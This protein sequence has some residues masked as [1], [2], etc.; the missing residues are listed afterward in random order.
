MILYN[1]KYLVHTERM[2]PRSPRGGAEPIPIQDHAIDNLRYIRET[3]ERAGSFTA[4]PGWGGIAIGLTAVAAGWV[5]SRQS[6]PDGW[7]GVWTVEGF[8][9]L[10]IGLIAMSAKARSAKTPLMWS[11]A[12][13]F[14]LSVLPAAVA[15]LALTPVLYRSGLA[16]TLAGMW[17]LLYGAGVVSGGAFSVRVVPLMGLCFMLTG[18]AALASPAAWATGF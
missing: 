2:A 16:G 18:T 1:E 7:L 6:F 9:A 5:A 13:K 14:A 12:R 17:L 11:P 4:V 3:M 8:A 10:A 15:A